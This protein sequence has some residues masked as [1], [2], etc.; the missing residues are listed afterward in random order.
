MTVKST[1]IVSEA[2]TY[3][4]PCGVIRKKVAVTDAGMIAK[5][6]MQTTVLK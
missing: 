5:S 3:L 6:Q 4:L 1:A 2:Q